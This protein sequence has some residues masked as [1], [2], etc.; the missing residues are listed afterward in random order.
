MKARGYLNTANVGLGQ[1]FQAEAAARFAQAKALGSRGDPI[2]AANRQEVGD[3]L[4]RLLGPGF[5]IRYFGNTTTA[6]QAVAHGVDWRQGDEVLVRQHDFPS[7]MGVWDSS[8]T[9]IVPDLLNAINSR[10][11]L[12]AVSHVNWATG[13]RADLSALGRRCH[14]VGALLC[15]DGV[16]AAGAIPLDLEHVDFYAVAPFKWLLGWFGLAFLAMRSP[17]LPAPQGHVNHPALFVLNATLGWLD[18]DTVYQRVE[19]LAARTADGLAARGRTVVTPAYRAGIVSFEDPD[20]EATVERL[21]GRGVFVS[22]RRGLVR[23]S[24]HFYNDEED[25]DLVLRSF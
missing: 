1:D 18:L 14:E 21:A 4:T 8:R 24:P 6:L 2:W 7:V 10:T 15:V 13:E 25:V 17:L 19:L 23:V 20:A 12:V 11:R 9:R 22:A 5:E 16:Q 3:R